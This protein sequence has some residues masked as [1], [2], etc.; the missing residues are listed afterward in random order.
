MEESIPLV[1]CCV[2]VCVS[3]LS[4]IKD[5]K[6]RNFK[7]WLCNKTVLLIPVIHFDYL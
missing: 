2:F 3:G 6:K 5:F 4:N 1:I 7:S